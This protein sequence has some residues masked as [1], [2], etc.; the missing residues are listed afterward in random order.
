MF[1]NFEMIAEAFISA[2]LNSADPDHG[3]AMQSC[4]DTAKE[5]ALLG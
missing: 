1:D 2:V 5:A 3:V 4:V